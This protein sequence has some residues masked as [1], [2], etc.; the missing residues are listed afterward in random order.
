MS[1][2]FICMGMLS[3]KRTV[4]KFALDFY[5]ENFSVS[6][7]K[8][9]SFNRQILTISW[10]FYLNLDMQFCQNGVYI[11]ISAFWT[12]R[13]QIV[14]IYGKGEDSKWCIPEYWFNIWKKSCQKCKYICGVI[15][16]WKLDHICCSG[17]ISDVFELQ[18]EDIKSKTVRSKKIPSVDSRV[19]QKMCRRV[20]PAKI[21]DRGLK[22]QGEK[23]T[24]AKNNKTCVY[25]RKATS[26]TVDKTKL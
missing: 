13:F 4:L 22:P 10:L 21:S 2:L 5:G 9:A 18:G 24:P 16:V 25:S 8:K 3:I 11:Y 14:C 15:L 1:K 17:Y 20:T 19:S 12:G 26:S 6:I 23:K 7:S